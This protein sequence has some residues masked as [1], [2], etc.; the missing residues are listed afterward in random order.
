M[1]GPDERT[2]RDLILDTASDLSG[3]FLWDAR[4]EDEDLPRGAI[5]DAI[6][7]G[8]VTIEEITEQFAAGLHEAMEQK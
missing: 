3:Q 1:T 2:R 4:K 8:E 5:E 6:T 7:A